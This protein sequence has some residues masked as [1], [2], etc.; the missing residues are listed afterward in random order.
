MIK[1]IFRVGLSGM[2]MAGC[3]QKSSLPYYNTPDFTPVWNID[4]LKGKLHTI[5]SFAFTNQ[6]NETVTEKTF[7]NTIYVAGFFFTGCGAVCP[8]MTTNL[9]KVQQAF[10]ATTD[11]RFLF[12]SVT[13]WVDSVVRLQAFA[14][15][16]G[17]NNQWQLVTGNTATIYQLARQS[18]FAEEEPGFQK[19]STEFLHTEH[20]LLIDRN[21]HIRGI[22]NGTLPL[23]ADRLIADIGELLK[24]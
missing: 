22:Y 18:Y 11:V 10:D 1:H 8:K 4:T 12:H 7:S 24:E 17:L 21:R 5:P 16:Y 6:R 20:L 19:D 15:R 2:I 13:P 14:K 9:L 3:Q 23:E